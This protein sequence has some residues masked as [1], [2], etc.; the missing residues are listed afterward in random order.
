MTHHHDHDHHH[1][2]ATATVVDPVCG[3]S[4]DPNTTD[5]HSDFHGTTYYFCGPGCKKAFDADPEKYAHADHG[6]HPDDDEHSHHH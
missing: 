6:E 5:L 4:I 3:M 1:H 2:D